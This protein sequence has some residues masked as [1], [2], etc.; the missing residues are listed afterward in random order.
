MIGINAF[1][2]NGL[3]LDWQSSVVGVAIGKCNDTCTEFGREELAGRVEAAATVLLLALAPYA[4]ATCRQPLLNGNG[5][6]A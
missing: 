3:I 2:E 6:A 1:D 5:S 4:A